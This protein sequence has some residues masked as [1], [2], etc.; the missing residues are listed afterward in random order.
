MLSTIDLLYILS[1]NAINTEALLQDEVVLLLQLSRT[2]KWH[3]DS[4]SPLL[5]NI[6][7]QPDRIVKVGGGDQPYPVLVN[8]M[9]QIGAF[10]TPTSKFHSALAAG[11]AARSLM[12]FI[13]QYLFYGPEMIDILRCIAFFGAEDIVRSGYLRPMLKFTQLE[14]SLLTVV[15]M[16]SLRKRCRKAMTAEEREDM[17][18]SI[19][20][21]TGCFQERSAAWFNLACR[22]TSSLLLL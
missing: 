22:G 9:G 8:F 10:R 17:R 19:N 20:E 12:N 4:M 5:E 6:T 2:S 15:W 13:T 14:S 7:L 3:S 16:V 21:G 1:K 18:I 11:G